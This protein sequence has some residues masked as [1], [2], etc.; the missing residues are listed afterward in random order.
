[1][2]RGNG[3]GRLVENSLLALRGQESMGRVCVWCRALVQQQQHYCIHIGNMRW[4][5]FFPHFCVT[6]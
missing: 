3:G 4:W 1:M 6:V 2:G 5:T